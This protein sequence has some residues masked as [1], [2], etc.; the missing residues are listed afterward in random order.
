LKTDT[1][2]VVAALDCGHWS[3]TGSGYKY[4]DVTAGS[5]GVQKIILSAKSAGG[6]LLVKMRGSNYGSMALTGPIAFLEA[7][8]AIGTTSYCGRFESPP[9]SSRKTS[10]T[11]SSPPARPLRA[12]RPLPP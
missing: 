6:K 4:G 1:G 3:A 7:Q 5:G 8:L 2:E 10:P 12:F 9:A 11:R